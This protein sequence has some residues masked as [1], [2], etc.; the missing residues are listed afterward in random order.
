MGERRGGEGKREIDRRIT[1]KGKGQT[2]GRKRRMGER[3][4]REG[5]E[6]DRRER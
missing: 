6:R 3:Q 5:K 4:E 2:G 1:E